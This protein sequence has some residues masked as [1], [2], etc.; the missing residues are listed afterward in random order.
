M[1]ALDAPLALI[2]ELVA[3]VA[4]ADALVAA[5][6]ALLAAEVALLAALFACCVTAV[7]VALVSLSPAPPIPRK[8]AI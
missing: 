5:E 7:T 6:E 4:A 8:I 2:A 1:A 3:E